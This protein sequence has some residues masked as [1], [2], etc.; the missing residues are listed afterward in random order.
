MLAVALFNKIVGWLI[1]VVHGYVKG[2][3]S[4]TGALNMDRGIIVHCLKEGYS[5]SGTIL[6]VYIEYNL[7]PVAGANRAEEETVAIEEVGI[8]RIH[9]VYHNIG[10]GDFAIGIPSDIA[11]IH[12]AGLEG[13]V[14]C[15]QIDR[16]CGVAFGQVA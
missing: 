16:G 11:G 4:D 13:L 8:S 10:Q 5:I 12:D 9:I 15:S 6:S 7:G 2:D 1:H 3:G 14:I